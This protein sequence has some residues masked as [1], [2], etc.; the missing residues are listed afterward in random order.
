MVDLLATTLDYKSDGAPTVI[1]VAEIFPP[2]LAPNTSLREL[3]NRFAK[4]HNEAVQC[5]RRGVESAIEAG[6]C[7]AEIKELCGHGGWGLQKEVIARERN[8]SVKTLDLYLGLAKA[9]SEGRPE[10]SNALE[11]SA[12][13]SIRQAV[14]LIAEA[15]R[16]RK[17]AT[18][19]KLATTAPDRCLLT[20]ATQD[21]D[22]RALGDLARLEEK[23]SQFLD[24]LDTVEKIIR[25]R[26]LANAAASSPWREAAP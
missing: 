15:R 22:S 2:K 1:G 11:N 6:L 24:L 8:V 26:F 12:E 20:P 19:A 21:R 9:F 3:G 7:L 16:E 25:L 13:L 14:R 18:A 10:I 4:A 5:T 23:W 17:Q